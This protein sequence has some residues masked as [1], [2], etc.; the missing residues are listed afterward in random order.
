MNLPLDIHR[1]ANPARSG[2]SLNT[3]SDVHPVTVNI[4]AAVHYV[5]DVN[6]DSH[7][8][9]PVGCN[10][11]V[12]FGECT[13]NLYCALRGFEGTVEFDQK[14]IADSFDFGAVEA[15]EKRAGDLPV[16]L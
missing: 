12:T 7:V 13:L 15:R 4:T 6:S 5:A 14:C 16:L 1:H 11:M 2:H 10:V 8:N 9:A 3:G